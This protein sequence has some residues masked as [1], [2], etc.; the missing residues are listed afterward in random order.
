MRST[1]LGLAFTRF[2]YLADFQESSKCNSCFVT[3]SNDVQVKYCRLDD[4]YNDC[5]QLSSLIKM[6]KLHAHVVHMAKH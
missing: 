2:K 4:R 3:I 1:W 6:T 5:R